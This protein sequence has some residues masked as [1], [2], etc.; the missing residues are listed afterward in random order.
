MARVRS[1]LA[2]TANGTCWVEWYNS[3]Y[4]AAF[5]YGTPIAYLKGRHVYITTAWYSR[6]TSRHMSEV[7][8]YFR[9][10]AG[11]IELHEVEQEEI[12]KFVMQ[13]KYGA[14]DI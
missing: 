14:E 10:M 13:K 12:D 7:I 9:D 4:A 6:T 2:L 5:S 11:S 3:F 1:Y 8:E